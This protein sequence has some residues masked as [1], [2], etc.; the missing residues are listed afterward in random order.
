MRV[1]DGV[2]A[3][4]IPTELSSLASAACGDTR[5]HDEG[6]RIMPSIATKLIVAAR[7][8]ALV[9][10]PRGTHA[11]LGSADALRRGLFSV[12]QKTNGWAASLSSS[13]TSM[14]RTCSAKRLKRLLKGRR[15]AA[16]AHMRLY[17][18]RAVPAPRPISGQ[19]AR[20]TAK[21]R[22]RPAKIVYKIEMRKRP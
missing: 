7:R 8:A 6:G 16:A 18:A 10:A 11:S 15:G 2:S 3:R 21:P 9:C 5:R 20:A 19:D 22:L 12:P 1:A 4:T 17:T 13:Q 14:S